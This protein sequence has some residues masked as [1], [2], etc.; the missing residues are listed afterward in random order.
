VTGRPH[1]VLAR[2]L[3]RPY[4]GLT[5]TAPRHRLLLP[6]SAGV[7]LVVK[8]R[9]SQHRAPAFLRGAHNRYALVNGDCARSY[10]EVWMA[11]LGAYRLLGMPVTEL[12]AGGVDEADVDVADVFGAAGRFLAE[13]VRAE[14]TWRGRFAL[15]DRFL[16][17]AADRGP[18]P[19]PEVARAWQ[20]LVDSGGLVAIGRVAEEVGWSHKRLITRF[21]QQVGL[22]P[23]TAARLV[24][25][26]RVLRRVRAGGAPRWERLAAEGGYADQAHL[27]REFRTFAGVTPT[28]YAHR[29]PIPARAADQA[30]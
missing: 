23:K 27:I 18:R 26:E 11:P 9:D 15:M 24:R 17:D 21:G 6:A 5:T 3:A 25:F 20:L 1:S 10:L 13:Q 30:S 22:T 19:L 29:L 7:S 2:L 12:A 8:L 14:P 16:L 28:A 4:S